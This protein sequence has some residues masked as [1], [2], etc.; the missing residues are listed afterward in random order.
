MM[1][2]KLSAR[3]KALQILTGVALLAPTA[4]WL[5][6]I[7]RVLFAGELADLTASA[8][9]IFFVP[10]PAL[11]GLFAAAL[12]AFRRGRVAAGRVLTV[13]TLLLALLVT[14]FYAV[15]LRALAAFN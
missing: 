5:W 8:L 4:V 10:P 13:T 12:S 1:E 15:L 3:W 2:P 7:Y 11:I 9:A 6:F 14:V